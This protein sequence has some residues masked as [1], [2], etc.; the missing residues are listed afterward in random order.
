MYRF[1]FYFIYKYQLIDN[2]GKIGISRYIASIFVTMAILFQ[3]MLLY[4]IAK[5]LLN[6]FNI[7]VFF[8]GESY[9]LKW[10]STAV[11]LF[12]IEI[13]VYRHYNGE[14]INEIT[15]YYEARSGKMYSFPNFVKFF[16]IY[17]IPL[18]I[19]ILVLNHGI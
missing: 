19:F 2:K 4:A 6:N 8:L 1:V 18:L 5:S 11:L 15:A 12:P 14:K 17:L 16:A 3:I 13:L 9:A 7:D 10:L